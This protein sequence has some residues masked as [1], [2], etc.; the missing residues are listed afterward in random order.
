MECL[1][2]EEAQSQQ[3]FSSK[4]RKMSVQKLERVEQQRRVK[5]ITHGGRQLAP[6][7][8]K[9]P[10]APK[11]RPTQKV[12]KES[13]DKDQNDWP[14]PSEV[15]EE[16]KEP[17]ECKKTKSWSRVQAKIKNKEKIKNPWENFGKM[18]DL[19]NQ[20]DVQALNPIV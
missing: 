5:I 11:C 9:W 16:D 8:K 13:T 17:A 6:C 12:D 7:R 14:G 1:S 4:T 20:N 3:D 15:H 2:N 18:P 19:S 10:K